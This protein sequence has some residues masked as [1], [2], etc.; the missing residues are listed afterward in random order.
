MHGNSFWGKSQRIS[1]INI[2]QLPFKKQKK[3]TNPLHSSA[4]GELVKTIVFNSFEMWLLRVKYFLDFSSLIGVNILYIV[5]STWRLNLYG[6]MW[7]CRLTLLVIFFIYFFQESFVTSYIY[8]LINLV[9]NQTQQI[10][11]ILVFLK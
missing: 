3:K 6:Y 5:T 2:T 7:K 8:F 4:W 9:S 1:L 10:I 11:F